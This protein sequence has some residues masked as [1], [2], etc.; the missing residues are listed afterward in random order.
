M[1]AEPQQR[2]AVCRLAQLEA[3][4]LAQQFARLLADLLGVR[5]VAG[6]V[7]D[8]GAEA[9][10]RM[11]PR[12]RLVLR[13]QLGDVFHL[14]GEPL[15]SLGVGGIVAQQVA[16]LLHPRAAARGVGD[17]RVEVGRRRRSSARAALRARSRS[18]ACWASEPQQAGRRGAST[19]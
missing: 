10:D 11:A 7:V 13:Q 3:G 9:G 14:G 4:D 19:A 1:P 8:D 17:D 2:C 12:M 16:V 15:G 18:P 6:V 5:E